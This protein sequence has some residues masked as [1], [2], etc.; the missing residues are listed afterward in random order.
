MRRTVKLGLA[1]I[2]LS[3]AFVVFTPVRF[4]PSEMSFGGSVAEIGLSV[5][6]ISN[7]ALL[8]VLGLSTVAIGFGYTLTFWVQSSK[9]DIIPTPQ[10]IISTLLLFG[11]VTLLGM[12]YMWVL[13]TPI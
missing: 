5:A 2:V 3:V 11:N 10:L 7:Y 12:A 13:T 4:V 9:T 6:F 8:V 1:S